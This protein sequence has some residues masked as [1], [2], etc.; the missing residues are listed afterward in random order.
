MNCPRCQMP[1]ANPDEAICP[2][3]GYAL[4]PSQSEAP[5]TSMPTDV[6][7]APPMYLAPGSPQMPSGAYPG[8]G[9]P[10]SGSL[11]GHDMPPP[12]PPYP[13][14]P[15]Y[16]PYPP[17]GVA[18]PSTI[19]LAPP[20]WAPAA[21]PMHRNNALVVLA[22]VLLIAV[23]AGGGGAL[24]LVANGKHGPNISLV[25][26]PTATRT[27][28]IFFQDPLT[29]NTNRW[30]SD[31]HCFF[32]GGGYHV[33]DNYLCFAPEAAVGDC[34]VSVQVRLVS[35]ASDA[36]FGLVVHTLSI[37]NSNSYD[38]Y[39]LFLI[40]SA[41]QRTFG[42]SVDNAYQS[43]LSPGSSSVIKTGVDVTNTLAVRNDANHYILYVNGTVVGQT[44]DPSFPYG[45]VGV[46]MA[47]NGEAVFN[48]FALGIPN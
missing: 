18:A 5:T 28:D 40:D 10:P 26:T 15:G 3:C 12:P 17:Y 47:D 38:N 46:I 2:S 9:A 48:N 32:K 25:P 11:Y 31:S 16:P 8:Y 44:D 27:E 41:G 22:I 30:A 7:A 33:K 6:P 19:P 20:A 37:G 39:Y 45:Y 1:L 29:T 21:A 34:E 43:I 42:K 13:P 36:F 14:Y 23:V 35:G 24:F 4:R